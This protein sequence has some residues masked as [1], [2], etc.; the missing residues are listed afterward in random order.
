MPVASDGP[1]LSPAIALLGLALVACGGD[2]GTN[3]DTAVQALYGVPDSGLHDDIDQDGFT[4]SDGDCNDDDDT[5]HPG[6][7]ETAG[8]GVDSDCDGEDDPATE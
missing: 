8:D 3:D 1:A 5:V 2:T 6:A 7:T 4:P